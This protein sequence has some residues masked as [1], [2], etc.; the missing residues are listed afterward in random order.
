MSAQSDIENV[1]KA[2]AIL[3][4]SILEH[5]GT[6]RDLK[7]L[8]MYASA[9]TALKNKIQQERREAVNDTS[10][11]TRS[12]GVLLRVVYDCAVVTGC[13]AGGVGV[14]EIL[15]LPAMLSIACP[16]ANRSPVVISPLQST[17]FKSQSNM[18]SRRCVMGCD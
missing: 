12:A 11:S 16:A 15:T 2:R 3:I 13:A 17:C 8:E 18:M 9:I 4:R 14:S 7:R 5:G 6:E 10:R 1:K